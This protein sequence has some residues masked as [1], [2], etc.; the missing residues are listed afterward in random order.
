MDLRSRAAFDGVVQ[1]VNQWTKGDKVSH[2]AAAPLRFSGDFPRDW[3]SI[4]NL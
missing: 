4:S 1:V 2:H 3:T